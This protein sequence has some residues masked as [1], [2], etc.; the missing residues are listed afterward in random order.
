M[1]DSKWETPVMLSVV[2][3]LLAVFVAAG[4]V[5]APL[6]APAAM[7]VMPSE[8]VAGMVN[9]MVCCPPSPIPS[10]CQK[11]PLNGLCIASCPHCVPIALVVS[12]LARD[13]ARNDRPNVD[14]TKDGLAYLPAAPPPRSVG[15]PA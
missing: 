10:D 11:C 9:D 6:A 2:R 15:L 7:A 13:P 4:M 3:Q 1:T 8:S 14:N 12:L 5:F